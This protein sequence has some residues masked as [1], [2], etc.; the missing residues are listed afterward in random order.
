MGCGNLTGLQAIN[1]CKGVV[2]FMGS[3]PTPVCVHVWPCISC[4]YVWYVDV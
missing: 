1:L 2:S 3:N 4:I